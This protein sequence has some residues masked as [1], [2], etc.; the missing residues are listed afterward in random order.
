MGDPLAHAWPPL[1]DYLIRI[2]TGLTAQPGP[3]LLSRERRAELDGRLRRLQ[4]A[5]I[6]AAA[7]IRTQIPRR[8]VTDA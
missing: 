3:G 6:R 1:G 4:S 2:E 8:E 7:E 5:R